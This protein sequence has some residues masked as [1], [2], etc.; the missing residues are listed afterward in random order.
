MDSS[1]EA[2][3][4]MAYILGRE[5]EGQ[6]TIQGSGPVFVTGMLEDANNLFMKNGR[7]MTS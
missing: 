4:Y 7:L 5:Q 2:P 1:V 3:K 6:V